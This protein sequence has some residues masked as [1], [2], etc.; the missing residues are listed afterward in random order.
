MNNQ[1]ITAL[2][3]TRINML[4]DRYPELYKNQCYINLF[5][6]SLNGVR[7]SMTNG[8]YMSNGGTFF[9]SENLINEGITIYQQLKVIL[10]YPIKSSIY[11]IDGEINLQ[12]P[13]P[14]AHLGIPRELNFNQLIEL[15]R[16]RNLIVIDHFNYNNKLWIATSLV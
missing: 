5:N 14:V 8:G 7:E 10:S 3:L 12:I 13:V 1:A 6:T 15:F 2:D 9:L 11:V 4:V 16:T